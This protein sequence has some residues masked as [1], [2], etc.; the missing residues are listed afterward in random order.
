[1]KNSDMPAMPI[2]D[3]AGFISIPESLTPAGTSGLT[4]RECFAAMAIQGFI[5][6]GSDGM[7]SSENLAIHAVDAAD[8]LLK[9]LEK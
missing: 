8:A 7:P 2:F 6:A 5:A 4:K 9:E 1:M 3:A